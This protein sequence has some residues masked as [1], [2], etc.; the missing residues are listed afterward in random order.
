MSYSTVVTKAYVRHKGCCPKLSP[1]TRVPASYTPG[2]EKT[3]ITL[4]NEWELADVQR[5][6]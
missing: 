1:L 6:A 3:M 4:Y 2:I 5:K